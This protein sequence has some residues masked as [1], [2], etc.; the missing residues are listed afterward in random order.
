MDRKEFFRTIGRGV[1][2][3][4]LIGGGIY[5]MTRPKKTDECELDFV[6][7]KCNKLDKCRLPEAK[8]YKETEKLR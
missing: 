4:A 6:C 1:L 3:A 8:K 2:F 7:K 5:L